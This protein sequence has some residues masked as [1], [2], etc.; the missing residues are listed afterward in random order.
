MKTKYLLLPL[1]L[2]SVFILPH[3]S[4][5]ASAG[6]CE[7]NGA[8]AGYKGFICNFS[9]A[10]VGWDGTIYFNCVNQVWQGRTVYGQNTINLGGGNYSSAGFTTSSAFSAYFGDYYSGAGAV[11]DFTCDN[12][13]PV[14]YNNPSAT[15][16]VTLS[17]P[18]NNLNTQDF[19]NWVIDVTNI[20]TS[21][22]PS[23][24]QGMTAGI[25]YGTNS[26]TLVNLQAGTAKINQSVN[27][28]VT[29]FLYCGLF[30]TGVSDEN[31][32]ATLSN[33]EVLLSFA[34]NLRAVNG[35]TFYAIP[36]VAVN[37]NI[38]A[39]GSII[40]YFVNATATLPSANT[41]TN[42][43]AGVPIMNTS[44]S[45]LAGGLGTNVKVPI[46]Q[47]A[48]TT[49]SIVGCSYT[50]GTFDVLNG[51][52]WQCLFLSTM[53][54]ISDSV[55]NFAKQQA[56]NAISGLSN[57]FPLSI[58]ADFNNDIATARA[59]ASTTQL[60][61]IT[62]SGAGLWG[63]RSF[64]FFNATTTNYI[65]THTGF[66]LRGWIAKLLYFMLGVT[67]LGIVIKIFLSMHQNNTT[68]TQ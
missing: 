43:A 29:D 12:P 34:K 14:T 64:T 19:T 47:Y 11:S 63:G 42:M 46:I 22:L 59:Q 55:Q 4:F 62:L 2:A 45:N 40:T 7:D 56:T 67:M 57:V 38:I 25:W 16:T 17:Y 35:E 49:T 61:D 20:N 23:Y 31:K 41:S 39:Q 1:L 48:T 33:S 37:N 15:P 51:S 66:D 50:N 30:N 3:Y 60:A 36:Y 53:Q 13:M 10:P 9:N 32:C 6:Y 18:Y 8:P 28:S 52:D 54:S 5:A 26:S 58:L 65:Q 24:A 21:T 27:V 68:T 44:S